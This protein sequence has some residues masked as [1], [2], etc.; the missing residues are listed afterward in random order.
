MTPTFAHLNP[1]KRPD[2]YMGQDYTGNYPVYSRSR[3]SGL[4]DQSNFHAILNRLGGES[5]TVF[6]VRATHWACGYVDT[7]YIHESDT[8]HLLVADELLEEIGKYPILDEDDY[9]RMVHAETVLLV[10]DI[11]RF[12]DHYPDKPDGERDI[13]EYAHQLILSR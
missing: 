1:W 9:D 4:I 11:N 7:I 6:V 5:E 2:Y 8:E 12:P 10:E 3:D 13:Y